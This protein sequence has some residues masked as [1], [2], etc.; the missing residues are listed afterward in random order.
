MLTRK[1]YYL[2]SLTL[3]I[4]AILL[5]AQLAGNGGEG[6]GDG[7]GNGDG[8]SK[9]THFIPK[10]LD[11]EIIVELGDGVTAQKPQKGVK[12]SRKCLDDLWYGGIGI[13]SGFTGKIESV[14]PGYAADRAGIKVGDFV[15]G[16]TQIRGEPGTEVTIVVFRP[17]TKETFTVT[18][19]REKICY[20]E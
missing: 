18:L 6:E 17:S 12:S 8:E 2:A 11:V 20:E 16:N 19:T 4:T 1:R 10:P 5:A 3:H 9:Q 13:Q 14:A 15:Q 7:N